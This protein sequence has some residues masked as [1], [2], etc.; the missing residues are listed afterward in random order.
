MLSW[1]FR[2]VGYSTSVRALRP[3]PRQAAGQ[4][5]EAVQEAS[6]EIIMARRKPASLAFADWPAVDRCAWESVLRDGGL[7]D[8]RG[9][10]AHWNERTRTSIRYD[11]DV[12]LLWCRDNGFLNAPGTGA[13]V[14]PQ[15]IEGGLLAMGE[16]VSPVT[17]HIRIQRLHQLMTLFSPE[18]DW[19][20]LQEIRNRLGRL[21]KPSRNKTQRIQDG[22]ALLELGQVH[23]GTVKPFTVHELARGAAPKSINNA[24]AVVSA[25]LNRAAKRWRTDEGEPWLKQAAPRLERLPL[26]GRQ[27]QP[28]PLSW[29]EQDK[30]VRLLHRP[31]ADA[32]LF[33][34]NTG[35]R[36]Q[37]VCSLRWDWE[38]S[39]PDLDTSIF[40][41]P[42]SIT[43]TETSRVIVLNSIS[44][45][46]VERQRGNKSEYVFPVGIRR[47]G[48]LHSSARKRAWKAS[49]LPIDQRVLKG[50]HN[51]RHT[52]GRRLRA[53]GVPLETR[54]LLLGHASGDITTHYSAAEIGELV[55]AV[56]RVTDRGIS[57]TPVLT[58]IQAH[59]NTRDVGKVSEKEKGAAT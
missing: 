54:R 40:V 41:L 47:R 51:L 56:E 55:A 6:A 19:H 24:L 14:E 38:V 49:G 1:V 28:Y 17:H 13:R 15:I 44:R 53:A 18:D 21:A 37:E 48:R 22:T 57:Q 52:F 16:H 59:Q 23:D 8:E 7:F 11:Y 26:A 10:A 3:D 35:C 50:V 42:A 46:I 5:L 39:V 27:A 33:T 45:R 58:L 34:V 43:K 32:V 12:W 30:L 2:K 25:I 9:G 29:E 31:L 4:I 20:W 36:D